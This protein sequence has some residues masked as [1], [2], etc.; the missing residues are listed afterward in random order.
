[1][2]NAEAEWIVLVAITAISALA[3]LRIHL[4]VDHG[5]LET[6]G[7]PWPLVASSRLPLYLLMLIGLLA[8]AA[9]ALALVHGVF[10]S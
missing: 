3:L 10:R 9:G 4:L 7:V 1:V 5:E 2:K 8:L 6:V